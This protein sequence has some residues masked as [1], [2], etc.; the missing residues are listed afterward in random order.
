M[1]ATNDVAELS[2]GSLTDALSNFSAIGLSN[3][4]AIL[5]VRKKG[6]FDTV[7]MIERKKER[8]VL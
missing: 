4:G 6:D 2:F 5:K 3:A 7:R 1:I 8:G